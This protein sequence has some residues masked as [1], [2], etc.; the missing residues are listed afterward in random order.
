[1]TIAF[2]SFYLTTWEEFHTGTLYLGYISGP[3]EGI[4]MLVAVY[5]VTGFTGMCIVCESSHGYQRTAM[6][7]TAIK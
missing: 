5:V 6:V 2:G 3:V 7:A 1:M 4:L